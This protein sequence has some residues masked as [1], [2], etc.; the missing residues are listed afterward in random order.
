MQKAIE[1]GQM[2]AIMVDGPGGPE[3]LRLGEVAA[4]SAGPGEVLVDI[5][6]A[7]VNR[8]DLLQRQGLY[9]PPPGASEIIGLEAAGRVVAAPPESGW[10]PG[11]RVC[12]LLS[13]GGYAERVAVPAEQ[14]L[15]IPQAMTFEEA[16]ALPEALCTVYYNLIVQAGLDEGETLLIHGGGSGIGT[17]AIQVAKAIGA[18][19]ACTAGSREKLEAARALGAEILINYH[20]EDFSARMQ[21]A[22]GAD[23]ILDIIGAKYLAANIAALRR[24]GRLVVIGLQGGRMGE[25]DLAMLLMKQGRVHATSL[26][27]LP[28]AEK[29]AIVA[30]VRGELWPRVESKAI[31]PCVDRVLPLAEAGEA[32]RLLEDGA[33]TGKI[34]LAMSEF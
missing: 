13:G 21:E 29:A 4:V 19:I 6:A 2:R 7:G 24:H 26:R 22:G 5:V 11:D 25:L 3:K 10:K 18:R 28:A 23:V 30:G 14:L 17:M 16:A 31:R 34:V 1:R 33:A 32:H 20:D 12:A 8:A 15:P 9:P 27:A